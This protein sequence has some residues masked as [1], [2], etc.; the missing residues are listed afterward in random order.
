MSNFTSTPFQLKT[1]IYIP[2]N[3]PWKFVPNC[4]CRLASSQCHKPAVYG[5]PVICVNERVKNID[6]FLEA[7]PCA[8]GNEEQ[9]SWLIVYSLL[10]LIIALQV[11]HFI[12]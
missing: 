7:G 12:Y 8:M 11:I 9:L 10:A 3:I 2:T 5:K 4:T 1:P 6:A